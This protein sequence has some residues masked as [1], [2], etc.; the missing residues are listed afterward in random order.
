MKAYDPESRQPKRL[1]RAEAAAYDSMS[2]DEI[3]L[4][5]AGDVEEVDAWYLEADLRFESWLAYLRSRDLDSQTVAQHKSAMERL[6]FKFF[7]KSRQ[8]LQ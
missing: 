4:T 7:A 2:D 1:P 6:A 3:R 8:D 5:L